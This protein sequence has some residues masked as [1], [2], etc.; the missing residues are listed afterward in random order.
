MT[1][2]IEEQ[3]AGLHISVEQVGRVHVLQAFEHLVDDILLVDLFQDV[4][5]DDRV[6]VSIHEIKD[7]VNIPIILCSDHVLQPD[8]VLVAD[9]FLQEDNLTEGSLSVSG[10]LEGVEVLLEGDNLL[11]ALIDGFPDNTVRALSQLL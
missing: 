8:D 4:S 2:G 10:I 7:K 1:L 9:K 3:V 11:G 6:Q 5:P